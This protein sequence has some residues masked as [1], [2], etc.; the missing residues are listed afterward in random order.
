[1]PCRDYGYSE[2]DTIREH[3]EQRDKLARIACKALT[4]L[5]NNGIVEAILLRDDE[6]AAWWAEHKEADRQ[7][8]EAVRLAQQQEELLER[9]HAQFTP[10]ELKLMGIKK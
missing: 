9:L 3:K 8:A 4:E 10:E 1:M 2:A 7:A 5:E 6:V